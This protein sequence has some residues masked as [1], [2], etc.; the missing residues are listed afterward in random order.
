MEAV[1]KSGIPGR[2]V[3]ARTKPTAMVLMMRVRMMRLRMMV[4]RRAKRDFPFG[5]GQVSSDRG[6]PQNYILCP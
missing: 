5:Q 6:A 1:P 2:P 4:G 3:Q